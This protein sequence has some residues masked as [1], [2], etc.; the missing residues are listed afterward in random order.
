MFLARPTLSADNCRPV[1]PTQF[2]PARLREH[3]F[4][5][6]RSETPSSR[7]RKPPAP[8]NSTH[9]NPATPFISFRSFQLQLPDI[10][11][12]RY[13]YYTN[14]PVGRAK[15][16][17][18]DSRFR[19][20]VSRCWSTRASSIEHRVSSIEYRVSSIEYRGRWPGVF[21][22]ALPP[23]K[24]KILAHHCSAVPLTAERGA[25]EI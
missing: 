3:R 20:L 9:T 14:P 13:A 25:N 16:L 23:D 19:I 18:L 11:T 22:L 17:C 1:N 10:S 5:Q 8:H 7:P 4:R 12:K 6:N 15:F 2:S 21:V 24:T